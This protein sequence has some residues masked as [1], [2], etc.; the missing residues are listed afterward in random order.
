MTYSAVITNGALVAFT[1]TLTTNYTWP[2]RIYL[3]FGFCVVVIGKFHLSPCYSY[4]CRFIVCTLD[5][6][7]V[8]R[9][10]DNRGLGGSR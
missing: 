1:S 2:A 7:S 10:K 5:L 8:N 6:L 9:R 4:C 3:F